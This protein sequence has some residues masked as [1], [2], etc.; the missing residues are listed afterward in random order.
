MWSPPFFVP[1]LSQVVTAASVAMFKEQ[2]LLKNT[3]WKLLTIKNLGEN[4]LVQE[5]FMIK[6]DVVGVGLRPPCTHT[7]TF[8][9]NL[10]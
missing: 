6:E 1:P 9:G 7:F 4:N 10:E 5:M 8:S 2:N 3:L